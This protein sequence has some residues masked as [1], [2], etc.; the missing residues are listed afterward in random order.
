MPDQLS[1][2]AGGAPAAAGPSLSQAQQPRHDDDDNSILSPSPFL[3][4]SP[5]SEP[6][7]RLQSQS[8]AHSHS[9][10]HSHSRSKHSHIH[11]PSLGRHNGTGADDHHDDPKK[12]QKEANTGDSDQSLELR[13]VGADAQSSSY[14]D[15][16][17]TRVVQTIELIQVVDP[18]GKPITTRTNTVPP[19]TVVVDR[20]SGETVAISALGSL[21][22][23]PAS[24]PEASHHEPS[25]SSSPS[26]SPPVT[27]S[28]TMYSSVSHLTEPTASPSVTPSASGPASNSPS[29]SAPALLP[30][31]SSHNNSMEAAPFR[32]KTPTNNQFLA[33]PANATVLSESSSATSSSLP[34]TIS[35]TSTSD[36]EFRST[37]SSGS[38]YSTWTEESSTATDVHGWVAGTG[39]G[40]E[41]TAASNSKS[42]E[43]GPGDLSPQQKQIVGGVVGSI[44]GVAFLLLLVLM[45]VKYKKRRNEV[46]ELIGDQGAGSRAITGPPSAGGDGGS[47]AA[48]P[49]AERSHMNP[50]SIPAAVIGLAGKKSNPPS[51]AA[52][53]GER[54]FVR[55]S[56]RKLPSVLQHGGDGYS[57]PRGSVMSGDS[58]YYRGSQAFDPSTGPHHLALGAPMRPVSGVPVMRSGPGRTAVT[59]QNPFADPVSPPTSP[60]RDPL[61]RT[62]A[63]QDGSRGSGSRFQENI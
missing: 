46:Q 38:T 13:D 14:D 29:S 22:S 60:P 10:S 2:A 48:A 5:D 16:Y 25:P 17:E 43:D 39:G 12:H 7:S 15:P 19:N 11:L 53:T 9:H 63:S 45:A 33:I 54:G 61:G 52:G 4:S 1:S 21:P 3:D 44:A 8:H 55:V 23:A 27:F 28:T 40:S 35:F 18:S 57:D 41:P 34:S 50:F 30:S 6:D 24:S 56:G 49:M 59:E 37:Y 32:H 58:D 62:F 36:E 51:P 47:G 31:G 26:Y 42:S 20:V